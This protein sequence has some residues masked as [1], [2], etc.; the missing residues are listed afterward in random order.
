MTPN[1]C[2]VVADLVDAFED[3]DPTRRTIWNRLETLAEEGAIIRRKHAN[4]NVTYR[5]PASD[6]P[7][8]E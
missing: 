2:Y 1:E 3:H 4:G 5:R 7:A 6:P 8:S